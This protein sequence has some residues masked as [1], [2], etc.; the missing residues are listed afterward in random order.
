MCVY[1][2]VNVLASV[3]E[4]VPFPALQ[5]LKRFKASLN[6]HKLYNGDG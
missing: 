4:L 2:N 1:L 5:S 3:C 6:T